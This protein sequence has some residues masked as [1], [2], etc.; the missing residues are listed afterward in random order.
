MCVGAIRSNRM[1]ELLTALGTPPLLPGRLQPKPEALRDPV[2][3]LRQAE[4]FK[5]AINQ[6]VAREVAKL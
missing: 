2:E 6:Q 4:A 1:A 3:V 5:E